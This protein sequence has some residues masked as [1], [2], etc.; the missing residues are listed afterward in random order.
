MAARASHRKRRENVAS[1]LAQFVQGGEEMNS[2]SS[3]P[4]DA[5]QD[6]HQG[7]SQ[8]ARLSQEGTDKRSNMIPHPVASQVRHSGTQREDA[9]QSAMSLAGSN[10]KRVSSVKS[11]K[12]SVVET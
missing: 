4:Q 2:S 6:V 12:S 8:D 5:P 9:A 7:A 11:A 10:T 1:D 3:T